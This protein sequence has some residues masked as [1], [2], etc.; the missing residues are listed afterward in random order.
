MVQEP[1]LV[2]SVSGLIFKW[3]ERSPAVSRER[4]KKKKKPHESLSWYCGLC[5]MTAIANEFQRINAFS[6]YIGII[7]I[8]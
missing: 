3:G 7:L 8:L 1:H 5:N 4:H 2:E 6:P